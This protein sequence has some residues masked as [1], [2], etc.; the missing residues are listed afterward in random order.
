LQKQTGVYLQKKPVPGNVKF[1]ALFEKTP[2][3]SKAID[4]IPITI[5]RRNSAATEVNDE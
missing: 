4:F 3:N 2:N 1:S 5:E